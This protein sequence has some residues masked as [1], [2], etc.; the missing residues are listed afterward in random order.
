MQYHL[1]TDS[2]ERDHNE[3]FVGTALRE[4]RVLY[5]LADGL[6]GHGK[7]EVASKTVVE[8]VIEYYENAEVLPELSDCIEYAQSILLEKQIKER[9]TYGMKTTL[10]IVEVAEDKARWAHVGDSRAYLFFKGKMINRTLDHSV[11]QMLVASGQIKEKEIRFH[12]DRNRLLKVMGV[13]WSKPM[14]EIGEW[15]EINDNDAFLLCS[16]GFWEWID[17]KHMEKCFK[18]SDSL[19]DWLEQMK[20]EICA[21]GKG[22][23][24]D[25]YSAIV[26]GFDD[27]L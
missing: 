15:F 11:P 18:K 4:N 22:K 2:G 16:D 5:I 27:G 26:V 23:N 8:S 24:M 14:Y 17:E 12:D 21:N 10:V 7:G 19:S 20:R 9:M 13:E 3:D 1:L 25:N 6:G